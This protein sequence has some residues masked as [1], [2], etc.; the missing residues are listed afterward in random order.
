[1][2][3]PEKR[4]KDFEVWKLDLEERLAWYL[5]SEPDFQLNQAGIPADQK[6]LEEKNVKLP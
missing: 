2:T 5:F 4:R 6:L 1:M 3:S